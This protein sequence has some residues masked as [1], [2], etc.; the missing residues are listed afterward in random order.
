M[1]GKRIPSCLLTVVMICQRHMKVRVD[2]AGAG[3]R[4]SVPVDVRNG[5]FLVILM[6]SVKPEKKHDPTQIRFLDARRA[7][8]FWQEMNII[9]TIGEGNSKLTTITTPRNKTYS[10]IPNPYSAKSNVT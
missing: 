8:S 2:L 7:P 9:I 5:I 10:T 3:S 4:Q 1:L 6:S